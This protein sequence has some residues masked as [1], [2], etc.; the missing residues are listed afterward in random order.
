MLKN[1]ILLAIGA[2]LVP[3]SGVTPASCIQALILPAAGLLAQPTQKTPNRAATK[4]EERVVFRNA[5]PGV[6]FVGSKACATCHSI[7]Y[8]SYLGTAMGRS[9]SLSSDPSQLALV[10]QAV[11]VQ[12]GG[13]YFEV[14]RKGDALYQSVYELGA[15]GQPL[16]RHTEQLRY[17]VGAGMSG[18]T[19]LV[20]R[21]NRLF[22]APLSYF[23][24][25]RSWGV[26]PGY[27]FKNEVFDRPARFQCIVCHVGSVRPVGQTE[28]A[29]RDPPFG[30][31]AIG[32]ENCHGPGELHVQERLHGA[33]L[34]SS[35]D[36]SI[37]N[38]AKLP[39]WLANNIC[40]ECH[41]GGEARVVRP[42]RTLF[43]F[44]PGTPLDDVIAIFR[45]PVTQASPAEAPHLA[46]YWSLS[47][48]RCFLGTAGKMTCFTCHD[49]HSQPSEEQAVAFFRN[50]C[51]TCHTDRSCRA[52]LA[53]RAALTPANNCF[54]C[55]M[56][57]AKAPP[58]THAD[59]T[60]HR[61]VAS[62]GEPPPDKF[63][64]WVT[65][66]L[67]D[68]ILV[69]AVP[70]QAHP[71]PLPTMLQAYQEMAVGD[72]ERYQHTFLAVLQK[73]ASEDPNNPVVL[74]ALASQAHARGNAEGIAK[75]IQDLTRVIELG[76]ATPDDYLKLGGLLAVSDRIPEAVSVL[77]KAVQVD[78]Y[79]KDLYPLLT[80]CYFALREDAKAHDTIQQWTNLFPEDQA[81]A[82]RV[83]RDAEAAFHGQ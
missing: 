9:A 71:I 70:D 78:P 24:T 14:A 43:D 54:G 63:L 51:L 53:E 44:R 32:C 36:V 34:A 42:G 47:M 73:T 5:S 67:Q 12:E 11:T 15:D 19:Y 65:P 7:I 61:I 56:P 22:E 6:A 62:R 46:Y 18:Y 50:R 30:Q 52:P 33:P 81:K 57:Q 17:V 40:M 59:Q 74:S 79:K 82:A 68:L 31:L 4:G 21:G 3:A 58:G 27:E 76:A 55:H 35:V 80:G 10:S 16:Y 75:A 66:G 60:V 1:R 26:S 38:P 69:N 29:Y 37:M 48:S 41:E 2:L 23:S 28:G 49:P 25:L 8:Q 72:A 77:E 45:A 13:R 83:V 39:P 20:Q 64:H